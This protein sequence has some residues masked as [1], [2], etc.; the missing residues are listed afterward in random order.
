MN[1]LK[2]LKPILGNLAVLAGAGYGHY[3]LNFNLIAERQGRKMTLNVSIMTSEEIGLLT[4]TAHRFVLKRAHKQL[5]KAG[6]NP[7]DFLRE[8]TELKP[9]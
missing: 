2:P 5:A 6:I 3:Q 8:N 4:Q 1:Q 9:A 7:N